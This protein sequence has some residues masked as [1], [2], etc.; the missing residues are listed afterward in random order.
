MILD[1]TPEKLIK[2][3]G[4]TEE[5]D[6][7]KQLADLAK[8]GKS[9]A[10][11][12]KDKEKF[13]ADL[14]KYL[15]NQGVQFAKGYCPEKVWECGLGEVLEDDGVQEAIAD[16]VGQKG[17]KGKGKGNPLQKAV[18]D[19]I[20]KVGKQALKQ[21]FN[22]LLEEIEKSG[23]HKVEEFLSN[24]E[25]DTEQDPRADDKHHVEHFEPEESFIDESDKHPKELESLVH[26][27]REN[28]D[29]GGEHPSDGHPVDFPLDDPYD[30]G[31]HHHNP[32]E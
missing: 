10:Q 20:L 4:V 19:A 9:E 27:I 29:Q 21:K 23:E 28:G 17:K 3:L 16:S 12:K 7:V 31:A 5:A 13:Y 22:D 25:K 1:K 26:H 14:R 6:L 8:G 24:L 32:D 11:T 30:D 18:M 15:V 2:D